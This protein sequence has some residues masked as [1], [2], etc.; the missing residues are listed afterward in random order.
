MMADSGY[1][2][3]CFLLELLLRG[4]LADN[5]N[6]IRYTQKCEASEKIEE[7]GGVRRRIIKFEGKFAL[8]CAFS[9]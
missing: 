7:F 3:V 1:L 4:G 8:L 9:Y 6:G 2:V 5:S